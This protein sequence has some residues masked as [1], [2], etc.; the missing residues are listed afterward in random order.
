MGRRDVTDSAAFRM[1]HPEVFDDMTDW[2]HTTTN[3]AVTMMM[4]GYALHWLETTGMQGMAAPTC[5][6]DGAIIATLP[7]DAIQSVTLLPSGK[8]ICALR[9]FSHIW[10]FFISLV[11]R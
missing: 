10:P 8:A 5:I 3:K 9:P 7:S 2:T 4:L 1:I 11:V 6:F